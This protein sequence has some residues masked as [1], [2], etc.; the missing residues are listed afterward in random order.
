M[1]GGSPGV[2]RGKELCISFQ[3]WEWEGPA[4]W[5]SRPCKGEGLS[6]TCREQQA[7]QCGHSGWGGQAVCPPW[8]QP[9]S[10]IPV[11]PLRALTWG[12]RAG[13]VSVRW[14]ERL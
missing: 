13:Q 10:G 14:A 9:L 1:T 4:R 12:R 3:N 11:L 5:S 8:S 7:P 2:G 6:G